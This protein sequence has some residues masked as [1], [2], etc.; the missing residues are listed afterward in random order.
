MPYGQAT[1]ETALWLFQGWPTHRAGGLRLFFIPMDTPRGTGLDMTAQTHY[2]TEIFNS[3]DSG[4]FQS[5]LKMEDWSG[6]ISKIQREWD[7]PWS[8]SSNGLEMAV[9]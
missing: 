1:L 2:F 4:R 8:S 3:R 9:T 7:R 5:E 6:K